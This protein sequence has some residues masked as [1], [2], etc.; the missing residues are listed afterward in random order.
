[1]IEWT[2]R[3]KWLIAIVAAVLVVL[4]VLVARRGGHQVMVTK[5]SVGSLNLRIAAS[6]LVEAGSTDL[7]F[8]STGKIVNLYVQ[9]GDVVDRSEILARIE[10]IGT[11][12][13]V[14]GGSDVIQA[15]YDGTVVDIYFRAGTV[16][17]PGQPV[18][19]VVSAAPPWV[20]AFI[21]SEDA[22]HIKPGHR[23]RCRA[24]GYLSEPWEIVVRAV[25]EEAVPRRDLPGSSSQV[26]VRCEVLNPAFSLTPGTEVDIDAEVPLVQ[27]AVLIPVAAVAHDGPDNWVWVVED[28]RARRRE[29]ELG[30]NNFDRIQIRAGL[31]PGDVVVVQGKQGLSDGQPVK[32]IPMPP[33]AN[34]E[35]GGA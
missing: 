34:Q 16:V 33:M 20:T 26:R 9:E 10:P 14:P 3:R 1:M 17:A 6:G 5:A 18:L 8:E 31:R 29:V 35:P 23:F 19:R 28:E 30:P 27:N 24:G 22:T 25:G 21:D 2:K 7:A 12:P 11:V 15:P 32:A 4:V 13:G